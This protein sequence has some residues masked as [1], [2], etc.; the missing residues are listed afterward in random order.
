MQTIIA[1]WG[2]AAGA[3]AVLADIKVPPQATDAISGGGPLKWLHTRARARVLGIPVQK[4]VRTSATG[5]QDGS[6]IS[7]K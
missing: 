5:A 4:R 1:S 6:L 3:L 2:T 7:T